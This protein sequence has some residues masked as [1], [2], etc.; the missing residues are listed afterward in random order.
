VGESEASTA[1]EAVAATISFQYQVRRT[2]GTP[3]GEPS[4]HGGR[5]AG[6]GSRSKGKWRA[7]SRLP[8]LRG[9]P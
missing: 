3:G 7:H 6:K 2:T 4:N 1:S 8:E 5:Q 9:G